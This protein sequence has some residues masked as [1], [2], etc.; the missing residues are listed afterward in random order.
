M[1]SSCICI[2]Q[3]IQ[4]FPD[5]CQECLLKW[6]QVYVDDIIF[7]S[8]NPLLCKEFSMLM[9]SEFEMSM[10]GELTFF[11]GL[12]IQQ[13]EE[14]TFIFQTKYTKELIKK[15]G[16]SNA[17]AI[18]TP[19]FPTTN[20]DKDEKGNPVDEI[21]YHGMIGSLL[22]LIA[23]R[24]YIMFKICKCARFQSAPMESH[25]TAVTRKTGKAPVA[26]VNYWENP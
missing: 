11:L 22:Y 15:F 14:G 9:Q 23:S 2:L 16:M 6:F 10:M 3:E 19:M 7:G 24:P 26:C 20:L 5:G 25:L 8:A 4:T 12:Q 13:S 21:K 17:K 18:G 1:N